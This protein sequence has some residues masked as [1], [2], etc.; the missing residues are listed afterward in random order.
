MKY[1]AR[2]GEDVVLDD[3][4]HAGGF[5]KDPYVISR[6]LRSVLCTP[7][8][9]KGKISGVLYLE[10]NHTTSAFTADRLDLLKQLAAQ[11]A[12][13]VENARL[14]EN[15]Q[16]ALKDTLK[17]DRAKTQFLMNMSH[18]LRTPLN[19][20][21]GYTEL[22]EEEAEDGDIEEFISDLGKIR[23]SA[24]RLLRT[25]TSI[26]ELSRL[27]VG[28][29]RPNI[30]DVSLEETMR[31]VLDEVQEAVSDNS[32]T[33]KVEN[34]TDIDKIRSDPWMLY[35]CLMSIL[36]N[37]CR[38][39]KNGRIHLHITSYERAGATWIRFCIRDTGIGISEED[40]AGLFDAFDQA[41]YSTTRTYEGSGV[42][43]AVVQ[44]FSRMLGGHIEVESTLGEGSAF[45]VVT[46][47]GL[48]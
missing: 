4:I 37:A 6:G 20:V 32:N 16:Q 17:A 29:S 15:L 8:V 9:H 39:T 19:A 2:T 21:I 42:S 33:L 46:P 11:I 34:D 23:V 25:L 40:M 45:T 13:S 1:V 36:D 35:Y 31:R 44:R 24:K 12:I 43:L 14:Y 5:I 47:A 18:E 22:I 38:F 26:L 3:A 10:N 27:Q 7:I 41:D 28:D 30:V 48:C